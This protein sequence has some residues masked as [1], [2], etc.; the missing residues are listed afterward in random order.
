MPLGRSRKIFQDHS[1]KC[2]YLQSELDSV[3]K[4]AETIHTGAW[5]VPTRFWTQF[6]S[7]CK[8]LHF[9][10]WSQKTIQNHLSISETIQ[11]LMLMNKLIR[12]HSVFVLTGLSVAVRGT[13]ITSFG[14]FDTDFHVRCA[15]CISGYELVEGN[16]SRCS[17]GSYKDELGDESCTQCTGN[18]STTA[19]GSTAATDCRKY[20]VQ[21]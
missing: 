13:K 10:E 6:S 1:T 16:C 15:V 11:N 21:C 7:L 17:V 8:Y 14:T 5:M 19:T 20:T 4:P 9:V 2:K 12:I 18:R 3:E